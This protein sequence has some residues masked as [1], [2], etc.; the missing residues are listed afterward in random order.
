M[1]LIEE[2][3]YLDI[4]IMKIHCNENDYENG[5]W[6]DDENENKVKRS[7]RKNG[8]AVKRSGEE[9]IGVEKENELGS[10]C[11]FW[12]SPLNHLLLYK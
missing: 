12:A 6:E 9:K 1:E 10:L 5:D 3:Q 2:R 4:V 8:G 7:E 11:G